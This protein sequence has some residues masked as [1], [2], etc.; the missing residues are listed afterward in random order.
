M[1]LFRK[2]VF[3]A[4]IGFAA[5]TPAVHAMDIEARGVGSAAI[6]GD[7]NSV[8][9]TALR[10]AKRNAVLAALDKV[11]GAGTSRNPDVQSKLDDLVVQIGEDSFY[12]MT[13]SSADG[14]Y[15]VSITLRMDDKALR[16]EISDL[17][18][19]LNTNTTRNQPILVMMDEFYTTPTDLHAPLEELTEFRHDAG[20]HYNQ[21]DAAASSS[22]SA[23]AASSKAAYA[24]KDQSAFAVKDASASNLSAAHDTQIAGAAQDG[25]GDQAAMAAHDAGH[26]N[27][28]SANSHQAAGASEHQVAA[29][30]SSNVAAASSSQSAYA[31][32]VNAEDHDNTYY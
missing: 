20:S 19:A 4:V 16:T 8:R 28:A 5:L 31:H 11:V 32:N 7:I 18:L 30:A 6:S 25:Y 1:K 26:V 14:Q 21:K 29:A 3:S 24:E 2:K 9:T 22:H 12:S 13:P 15:E 10:Q 27:A 17:G 23:F